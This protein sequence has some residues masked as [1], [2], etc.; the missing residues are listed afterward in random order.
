[1]NL[2]SKYHTFKLYGAITKLL[3]KKC[4]E[5]FYVKETNP[6]SEQLFELLIQHT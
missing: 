4:A 3:Y 2:R 5:R 1:M 6:M